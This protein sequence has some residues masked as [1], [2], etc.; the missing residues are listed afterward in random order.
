M[1]DDVRLDLVALAEGDNA[2]ELGDALKQA[3]ADQS[4]VGGVARMSGA[5]LG[6]KA[7]D[8]VNDAMAKL[9]LMDLFGQA[10]AKAK[11][12]RAYADPAQHPQDKVAYVKLGKH[13]VDF[14][15]KPQ[16]TIACGPWTSK[17][18]ELALNCSAAIE[19]VELRIL[20]GRLAAIGGGS[21][22]VGAEITL[23]GKSVMPRRTL[24][25]FALPG[26]HTFDPGIALRSED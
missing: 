10:W 16:V 7:A 21:C 23:L 6:E 15:L 22:D 2:V 11:E 3:L 19:A 25:K 12:I 14:D 18:I 26:R 20:G 8:A 1:S 9:D 13:N 24:K 5:W 4:P 17:P